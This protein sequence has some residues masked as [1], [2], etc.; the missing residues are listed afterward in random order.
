MEQFE[1]G[2]ISQTHDDM[3]RKVEEMTAVNEAR[4]DMALGM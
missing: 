4:L 2:G 3:V 1:V